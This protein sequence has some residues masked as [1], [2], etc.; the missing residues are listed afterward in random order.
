VSAWR[1][2]STPTAARTTN[3]TALNACATLRP[4]QR[5][6]VP[7]NEYLIVMDAPAAGG[8]AT[9]ATLLLAVIGGGGPG[10]GGDA[11]AGGGALPP[12]QA[13]AGAALLLRDCEARL[14]AMRAEA[15]AMTHLA[16]ELD[17]RLRAIQAQLPAPQ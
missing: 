12:A 7:Y 13:A 1:R 8:G 10:G 2:F 16:D 3:T 5:S 9:A 4:L 6:L 15:A 14:A 11:P 17:A